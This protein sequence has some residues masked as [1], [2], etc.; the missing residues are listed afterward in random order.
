MN[1]LQR[2]VVLVASVVPALVLFF[3]YFAVPLALSNYVYLHDKLEET[4]VLLG[5]A[6]PV[7]VLAACFYFLARGSR[8]SGE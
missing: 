2:R 1:Q 3:G 7:I 4:N 5:L 8:D 6:T